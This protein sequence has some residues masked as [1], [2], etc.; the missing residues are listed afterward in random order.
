MIKFQG[1]YN[2]QEVEEQI[3][4]WWRKNKIYDKAKSARRG[5]KFYF[6]D[7]PPYVTNPPHVAL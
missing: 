1:P 5:P 7:G 2:P 3:L 4:Q 6:L